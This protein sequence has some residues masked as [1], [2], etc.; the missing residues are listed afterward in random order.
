MFL[1]FYFIFYIILKLILVVTPQLCCAVQS[2][3]GKMQCLH[4]G[5]ILILSNW[6][7]RLIPPPFL[8]PSPAPWPVANYN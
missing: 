2:K 7:S 4:M 5:Q 1:R 3:S 6:I 8:T